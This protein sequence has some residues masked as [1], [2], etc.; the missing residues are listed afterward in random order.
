MKKSSATADALN[1]V[2]Y[3]LRYRRITINNLQLEDLALKFHA[4]CTGG[5]APVFSESPGVGDVFFHATCVVSSTEK[6]CFD[7]S[8]TNFEQPM[9]VE[10]AGYSDLFDFDH[11]R[12]NEPVL[13]QR[14]SV[15]NFD[16]CF[17]NN[18][19]PKIK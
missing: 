13:E 3:S 8:F 15:Y 1:A 18:N 6:I 17:F 10:L 5:D 16:V 7:C 14:S 2:T 9:K 12:S 4:L 11:N 19:N